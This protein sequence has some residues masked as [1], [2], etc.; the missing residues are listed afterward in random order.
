MSVGVPQAIHSNPAN[1]SNQLDEDDMSSM[2]FM[3]L[4]PSGGL[5]DIASLRELSSKVR[6]KSDVPITPVFQDEGVVPSAADPTL[7]PSM[8]AASPQSQLT[9]ESDIDQVSQQKSEMSMHSGQP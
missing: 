9:G 5:I 6:R 7:D 3:P 4:I 1:G 2:P 8:R